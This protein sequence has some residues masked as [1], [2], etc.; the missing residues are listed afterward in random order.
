MGFLPATSTL[1]QMG[2]FKTK[3]FIIILSTHCHELEKGSD[4]LF[5]FTCSFYF[6]SQMKDIR[7]TIFIVLPVSVTYSFS[8]RK[9]IFG[10]SER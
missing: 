10:Y 3:E 5:C 2:H 8:L 1:P 6:I 9:Q 4:L 7:H